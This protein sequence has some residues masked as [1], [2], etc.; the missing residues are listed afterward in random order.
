M[1]RTHLL[2]V[3][4]VAAIGFGA[5]GSA[6]AFAA[7][8]DYNHTTGEMSYTT[9]DVTDALHDNDVKVLKD[10]TPGLT[11]WYIIDDVDVDDFESAQMWQYCYIHDYHGNGKSTFW[12]WS[13]PA[14]KISVKTLQGDDKITVSPSVDIP[15]TLVGGPGVDNI[16]GG[17]GPDLIYGSCVNQA[18]PA[19]PCSGWFDILDGGAGP[20]EIHGGDVT[21]ADG[22]AGDFIHG[23]T[24][25]DL[26]DGGGGSD[27]VYGDD[28]NDT[29]MGGTG[30]DTLYGGNGTD[31]ASYSNANNS[32]TASLEGN[33]NDGVP[34]ENDL[35]QSD[36]EGITGG[37]G[38]DTLYGNDQVNL[39]TGGPGDDSLSGYGG[40]DLLKGEEGSDLLRPGLGEDVVYGGT[41]AGL[42]SG[43][44]DTVTYSERWNTVNVSLDGV[45]ND[46][47]PGENDF[48]A[49]DVENIT[50]GSTGDTLTGDGRGNVLRG[51]GGDDTL[52][53]LGGGPMGPG[54]PGKVD[55]L[56]GGSGQD[57]ID[58]GPLGSVGDEIWGGDGTDTVTYENRS[59][60]VV[61]SLDLLNPVGEDTIH[62]VE[63]AKGGSGN[64]GIIGNDGPNI[65]WGGAGNDG[66]DGEGGAD[67]LYG[68]D[69]NDTL[70]GG[71]G[72][73][74]LA[75]NNGADK[76]F[77]A[78]GADTMSGGSGLDET[79]YEDATN[80]VNVTLDGLANDGT[81][82]EGDNVIYDVENVIGSKFPDKIT[83]SAS[84]NKLVGGPGN[85]QLTGG[86]G[87]DTLDGGANADTLAGGDGP[88]TL[89]GGTENDQLSGDGGYDTLRGGPGSDGL[90][91]GSDPDIADFSTSA[92][93]V[94]VS[95]AAGSA[96]GEG[97][98]KLIGVEGSYGSPFNDKLV[99][100]ANGNTL[101]GFEGDDTIMGGAGP[102]H[103]YGAAGDD[104][105]NGELG[106]DEIVGG[107]GTDTVTYANAPSGVTVDMSTYAATAT[108]GAGND[109][110]STLENV[111]GSPFADSVTG[112]L[113][114]NILLG[115]GGN[116]A[117]SALGG[118]DTLDGGAN[119]DSV[120]GGANLD[121][122]LGET[123]VNCEK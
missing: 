73:D 38:P 42:G 84:D 51:E 26:V 66:I 93:P 99:G 104:T 79:S 18:D 53:G 8:I 33:R 2:F 108:G 117:L 35:I 19:W 65:L 113:G 48:V 27:S 46:G 98:D 68:G 12:A 40:I 14:T 118:N 7:I 59:D 82:G 32:V 74:T 81:P 105:L 103:L 4:L 119:V 29:V 72:N 56:L 57:T 49:N 62:T 43:S 60:N 55:E 31:I 64:N 10:T 5:F 87:A 89:I 41:D 88:D 90:N 112:S 11:G 91:G 61:I 20:D 107:S 15:T 23:G 100:D 96:S 95:L 44:F 50:G 9:N 121:S 106:N 77:G 22:G 120:D 1:K 123:R 109:M 116:D 86:V 115:A 37:P 39:L 102:D 3:A 85:D 94:T 47:E 16:Q 28:N 25:N 76:L 6:N 30:S 75:G 17:A 52:V 13:C 69:D 67:L 45:A 71:A 110:L 78:E 111:T 70:L 24:G 36:V 63:N 122:C 34:G 80:G 92:S 54:L 21:P 97:T 114:A 58:G 83:G 101:S